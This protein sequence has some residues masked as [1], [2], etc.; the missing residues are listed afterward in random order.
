MQVKRFAILFF[1]M[2]TATVRFQKV[3]RS[4]FNGKRWNND[5]EFENAVVFIEFKN[6]FGVGISF[7]CSCFHH[8]INDVAVTL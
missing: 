2:L 4:C 5:Y 8:Y 6:G 3:N 1:E 7:T